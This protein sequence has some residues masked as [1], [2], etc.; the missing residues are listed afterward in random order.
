MCPNEWEYDFNSRS[1]LE[2]SAQYCLLRARVTQPSIA[3]N[4]TPLPA[5]TTPLLLQPVS[6]SKV[7]HS[8]SPDNV[9][10]G[11][12][13]WLPRELT[14]PI[15]NL[16]ASN[17]KVAHASRHESHSQAQTTQA[18]M[19]TFS[20]AHLLAI[21]AVIP[22]LPLVAS[23]L[24]PL[25]N[26]HAWPPE[27]VAQLGRVDCL[28]KAR[29]LGLIAKHHRRRR[30]D[31]VL[32]DRQ[33]KLIHGAVY[34]A[35]RNGHVHVVRWFFKHWPKA[36]Q[37]D[38]VSAQYTVIEAPML[39]DHALGVLELP[40][41]ELRQTMTKRLLGNNVFWGLKHASHAG[42][43]QVLAWWAAHSILTPNANVWCVDWVVAAVE[44]GFT[45]VVDLCAEL[46]KAWGVA[47]AHPFTSQERRVRFEDMVKDI[48]SRLGDPSIVCRCKER[49]SGGPDACP[50]A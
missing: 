41:S 40:D 10:V 14:E 36:V 34:Q 39:P 35:S 30:R 12:C 2:S 21:L 20:Q 1:V 31:P 48:A 42:N 9:T 24:F 37:S 7:A 23:L 29:S 25:L 5:A 46:S 3:H 26:T 13:P 49:R 38:Q 15:L 45:G 16:A 44:M 27:L 19:I 18:H 22:D 50:P 32:V 11:A 28:E 33:T 43:I 47:F 17:A 4:T 6:M 8:P